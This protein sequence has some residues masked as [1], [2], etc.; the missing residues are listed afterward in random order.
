MAAR[1]EVLLKA[2]LKL[3]GT[4][5]LIAVLA[6]AVLSRAEAVVIN[7]LMAK[8]DLAL[9]DA[10]GTFPDW[11]ELYNPSTRAVSLKGWSLSND[12]QRPAQWVCPDIE[13]AAKGFL[14]VF[15]S[16]RDQRDPAHELHTNFQLSSAGE[17]LGLY[18]PDGTVEDRFSPFYPPQFSDVS[19]GRMQAV[20]LEDFEPTTRRFFA[21]ATPGAPNGDG[22]RGVAK[23]PIV[24]RESG[25]LTGPFLLEM[26]APDGGEIRWTRDASVPTQ[27]S[28]L[29]TESISIDTTTRLRVKVFASGLIE[30]PVRTLSYILLEEG[31]RDFSSDLPILVLD[32]FGRTIPGEPKIP[33]YIHV[34]DVD[35]E[36][37]RSQLLGTPQFSGQRFSGLV[38]I[39]ARGRSTFD[40]RKQSLSLEI[41]DQNGD[42]LNVGLLGMPPESDWVLWGPFN[43]DRAMMRNP[44]MYRLSNQIGRYAVRTQFCEI[45]L[46]IDGSALSRA[47]D[48]FG[49][50]VF[51]EKVKR[52]PR[53]VDVEPLPL[54][55]TEEP[56]ISGGYMLKIDRPGPRDFGF[57]AGGQKLQYLYPRE[58]DIPPHQAAWI[59]RF[60]DDFGDALY[61]EDFADPQLGYAKYLDVGAAID[62]HIMTEFTKDPDMFTLSTY[63]HKPRGGKLTLGP[64]WDFDHTMG[65]DDIVQALD[66]IGWSLAVERGWLGR[67]FQDPSFVKQYNR[68]W[69]ELRSGSMSTENMHALVDS[70][71]AELQEAQARNYA[72]WT[73]L[74]SL[75][76]GYELE[77]KQLKDWIE[78][79]ASWM[80]EKLFNPPEAEPVGAQRELPVQVTLT[81]TNGTGEIYYTLNAPDPKTPS[82]DLDSSASIYRGEPLL[83]EEPTRL[84]ARIRD[85]DFW[86]DLTE[87]VYYAVVPT[88]ALTEILYN[89]VDGS[90]SEFLELHNF[91]DA[92]ERLHGVTFWR[93]VTIEIQ[94]GP[95]FLQPG[96]YAVIVRDL[97]AFA[98]RHD[99]GQISVSGEYS[100]VLSD[101]GESLGLDGP[102]GEPIFEFSYS[103]SW[104]PRTDGEGFSLVLV[105]PKTA[106]E[107]YGQAEMWRPSFF[108]NGSPGAEDPNPHGGQ[109]PGDSNQDGRFNLS[110]ALHLVGFVFN[111]RPN[112]LPC[113]NGRATDTQN[114][115]LLD[116]NGD[117]LIDGS[118][119][120]YNLR[121][122]F[123]EGPRPRPGIECRELVGCPDVCS[124]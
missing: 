60:M 66:P 91:G 33:G 25:L 55:A 29:Y 56:E 92:P 8:N 71:A 41:R 78:A 53:R 118:D 39:E 113:L 1:W 14:V 117:F 115:L 13:L 30:S 104:H 97:E 6:N 123:V 42:D 75:D 17:F 86:S 58:E 7:E 31:A 77:V 63:M 81:N 47:V 112:R 34:I 2:P 94:D 76:G 114:L 79:R 73:G 22:F 35:P 18:H 24:S 10:A 62:F 40:R 3:F 54:Q 23:P 106:R 61:G 74:V 37:G 98:S 100:G 45:F 103:E 82:G 32:S 64:V 59:Q 69:C 12:P 52:G 11:L 46:N 107:N 84:R 43:F 85:G 95:E 27:E 108:E 28:E 51:M 124:E 21:P 101:T 38:G 65:G 121:Y 9:A 70:M 80:D 19:Y 68:R 44:F 119:V 116:S 20:T 93:G 111:G 26:T 109:L 99:I 5:A 102:V 88:I 72:R 105:D 87:E 89:P 49:V 16:G 15:C 110:D 120:V 83:I 4:I 96:E 50:Y 122:L 67:L 57:T 90:L 36:T 48:Y